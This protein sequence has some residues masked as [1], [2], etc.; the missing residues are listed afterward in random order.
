MSVIELH[1]VL[2]FVRGPATNRLCLLMER[3]KRA[4]LTRQEVLAL[5]SVFESA[6]QRVNA[7]TAPMLQLI[8][9]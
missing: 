2:D 8:P 7:P 3:V 1:D 9:T 5:I 6:D 4:D